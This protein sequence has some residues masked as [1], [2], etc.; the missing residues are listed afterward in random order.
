M[1]DLWGA[2]HFVFLSNEADVLSEMHKF[3]ASLR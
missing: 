2:H 3:A 1:V